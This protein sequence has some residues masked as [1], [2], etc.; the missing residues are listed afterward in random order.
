MRLPPSE[1]RRSPLK[2]APPFQFPAIGLEQVPNRRTQLILLDEPEFWIR[3]EP[4]L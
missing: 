2:A 3:L 4:T 1:K